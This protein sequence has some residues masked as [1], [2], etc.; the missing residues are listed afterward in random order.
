MEKFEIIGE[1]GFVRI[2]LTKVI[3]FPETTSVFGGY[4]TESTIEIRSSNYYVKG[5][6]WI[7][8]GNIFN[9]FQELEKCQKNL[10]GI[11]RLESYE[12]NLQLTIKYDE[13]G[14]VI[15][16]GKFVENYMLKNILDFEITGDQTFMNSTVN[17]LDDIYKKY[18]DN[19]GINYSR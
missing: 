9:F 19:K 6:L 4:D 2:I 10:D 7:T 12:N 16:N 1:N 13:T 14:H 18:G 15:T 11:A 3:G 17:E 5:L 8:T